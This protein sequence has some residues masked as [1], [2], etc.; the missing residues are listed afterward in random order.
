[1]GYVYPTM[2]FFPELQLELDQLKEKGLLRSLRDEAAGPAHLFNGNDYLGL[3]KHPLVLERAQSALLKYGTG[4][5]G[6]RLLSGNCP[7]YRELETRL[8]E[9]HGVESALVVQS[10][11]TANFGILTSLATENDWIVSDKLNHASL[12]DGARASGATVRYFPHRNLIRAKELLALAPP[13]ARK[14]IVSDSVFSMDGDLCDL[15]ALLDLANQSGSVLILDHAHSTGVLG[16]R[17]RGIFEHYSLS[18]K[19]IKETLLIEMGTLSKAFGGVGAYIYGSNTVIQYLINKSRPFIYSTG[20]PPSALGASLGALEILTSKE[21]EERIGTLHGNQKY[22]AELLSRYKIPTGPAQGE[23]PIFSILLGDTAQTLVLSQALRE[24]GY[25]TSAV[26]PPTVP[27]NTS[28]LRITLQSSHLRTTLEVFALLIS[29]LG[30]F[31]PG[32]ETE[33]S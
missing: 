24:R 11:Y 5:T 6:S 32:R 28:R 17:G 26:R 16:K 29:E 9:W 30:P 12:I 20:L 19:I 2:S 15:P 13:K 21:G 8:A 25:I 3:S 31:S 10:G 23:T 18:R 14:F 27:P 1:M 7:L 33:S 4:A 22:F